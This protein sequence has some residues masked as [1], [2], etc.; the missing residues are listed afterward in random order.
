MLFVSKDVLIRIHSTT[1][2]SL[3]YLQNKM[4]SSSGVGLTQIPST[5]FFSTIVSEF[6][7]LRILK[8][9]ASFYKTVPPL[10]HTPIYI[11]G[12]REAC[13]YLG[14][15]I[16]LECFWETAIKTIYWTVTSGKDTHIDSCHNHKER[17]VILQECIF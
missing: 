3:L 14:G 9:N 12:R 5:V 2:L 16:L 10:L 15:C 8:K 4:H 7:R 17:K 6:L 1:V 13:I 11:H